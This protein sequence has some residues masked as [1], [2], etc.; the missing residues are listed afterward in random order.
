VRALRLLLAVLCGFVLVAQARPAQATPR[1]VVELDESAAELLDVQVT[2]RLI[3]LELREIDLE[4]GEAVQGGGPP[5]LYFRIS[6]I[7]DAVLSIELWDRGRFFGERR[8]SAQG[9]ALL[10]ARRLALASAELARLAKKLKEREDARKERARRAKNSEPVG[11]LLLPASVRLAPSLHAALVDDGKLW[12]LGPRLAAALVL[13]GGPRLDLGLGWHT[14]ALQQDQ[15]NATLSW[16]ELSLAPAYGWGFGRH[17]LDVGA[18]VAVSVVSGHDVVTGPGASGSLHS[19]SAQLA[20]LL[21]HHLKL[22]P[23]LRLSTGVELGHLLHPIELPAA[24]EV[25]GFWFGLSLGVELTTL[26][27]DREQRSR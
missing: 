2:R 15:E 1:S 11:A 17:G 8:V 23:R 10:R 7:S 13:H 26:G 22:A 18:S 27:R 20:L 3:Q 21:R 19:W 5:V 25:N 9:S 16:S 14:G 6:A 12:L 24:R 4:L